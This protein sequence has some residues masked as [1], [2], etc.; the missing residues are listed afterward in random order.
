VEALED[1][2]LLTTVLNLGDSGAGSLRQAIL[3][4]PDAGTV[5]FAAGLTGTITLTSGNL[6]IAKNLTVQGPGA[7]VLT[8]SGGGANQIFNVASGK[9]VAI[10]GLTLDHGLASSFGGAVFNAG[11]LKLSDAVVSNSTAKGAGNA[12]GLGGGVFNSGSLTLTNV[13]VANNVALPSG[14]KPASGGGV[15]S[16]PQSQSLTLTNVTVT[17]NT[18]QRGGGVDDDKAAATL[19]NCTVAGNTAGSGGQGG[20]LAFANGIS[21]TVRNTLAAQNTAGTGPDVFGTVTVA[22]HDL[23]GNGSGSSGV[24]NG[25]GGNQVGS[26][27]S[28]IDPKV[29]KLQGNG[30]PTATLA[31]LGGSPAVDAGTNSN[32]PSTDQRGFKRTVNNVTDIGAYEF[33]PPATTTQLTSSAANVFAGQQVTLTASV[34]ATAPGSNAIPTGANGAVKFMDGATVLG[35]VNLSADGTAKLTATLAAGKHTLAAAYQGYALGDYKFDTSTSPAATVTATRVGPLLLD[36]GAPGQLQLRPLTKCDVSVGSLTPFGTAYK[37]SIAV[38]VGDLN[39]DGKPDFV[40]AARDGNPHV[41]VYNGSAVQNGTFAANPDSSLFTQFFAYALN[42][43]VGVNVALGDVNGDG[44]ADLVTGASAGNPHVKVYDGKAIATGKFDPNN[45]DASLLAQWF[46]YAL[47]FN[48]GANVAVGDLNHDGF[49]DVVT[50]ATAGNPDVRVY[51]GKD[52]AHHTFNPTGGSLLAHFFG[53][54][55]NFNVGAFVATGDVNGD[56]F[57]DLLTGAS[58]GNPDVRVYDGKA[59]ANG[60]FSGQN[61]QASWL[62]HFFAYQLQFDI[63]VTLA[64]GDADGDGVADIITGAAA[65]SPHLRIVK[66][67]ATGTLP[68]AIGEALGTPITGG[69]MVGA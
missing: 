50:A 24:V 28:P 52:I 12:T 57:V 68:P 26:T 63:G 6:P 69:I 8:V 66:G 29:G 19:T 39:K 17:G 30:G 47:Q 32:A 22:D 51:S 61:P 4:T 18:S 49:A 5:N 20:G 27:G 43:N 25:T 67:N 40:A 14:S 46:P 7:N 2:R 59:F 38:A 41:K 1:R 9:T 58:A 16:S 33:Q 31:L 54:G 15:Y 3:D 23:V 45:P 11:T 64:T 37:G 34:A 35:A 62:T 65:G 56:G 53:Y 13:L 60:T 55:L 10:S 36:A 42:F 21:A 44:Y 48:V